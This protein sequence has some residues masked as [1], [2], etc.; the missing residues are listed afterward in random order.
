MCV[1]TTP[2][3][4]LYLIL[5]AVYGGVEVKCSH[6]SGTARLVGKDLSV[7]IPLSFVAGEDGL[8]SQD[9]AVE[10]A[11]A[12]SRVHGPQGFC[13]AWTRRTEPIFK[14]LVSVL[15]PAMAHFTT[16][17]EAAWR[18]GRADLYDAVS[19]LLFRLA[20]EMPEAYRIDTLSDRLFS[21]PWT[22]SC[23]AGLRVGELAQQW[24]IM[25]VVCA[26]ED[27]RLVVGGINLYVT[28]RD[29]SLL[30]LNLLFMPELGDTIPEIERARQMFSR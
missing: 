10:L 2:P 1:E 25:A 27:A 8:L 29:W 9:D 21:A 13:Y 26:E 4:N 17:L 24:G 14:Q 7:Q 6:A 19:I 30:A 18:C 11:L 23:A 15:R 5:N 20:S 28:Q 22:L 16:E 12:C 3:V